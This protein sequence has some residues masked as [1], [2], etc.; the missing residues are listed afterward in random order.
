ML[1]VTSCPQ[2]ALFARYRANQLGDEQLGHYLG[3]LRLRG[4]AAALPAFRA[5]LARVTGLP[6]LWISGPEKARHSRDVVRFEASAL[7]AFG[8]AALVAAMCWSG[9]PSPGTPP[10]R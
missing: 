7:F 3:V 1:L 9:S 10:A 5:D 8:L 4:G 2:L 6:G